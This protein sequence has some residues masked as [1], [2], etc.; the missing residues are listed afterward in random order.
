MR[1]ACDR[2]GPN[3]GCVDPRPRRRRAYL[4]GQL[5]ATLPL[6][7]VAATL[8]TTGIHAALRSQRRSAEIAAGYATINN[9]LD[10]LRQ[11]TRAATAARA[12]PTEEGV[13]AF[14]LQ[15]LDGQISYSL[16]GGRVTRAAGGPDARGKVTRQWRIKEADLSA[17]CD[18]PL[19]ASGDQ[20]S[21]MLEPR[22]P[23]SLLMVHIR[24]RGESKHQVDPTRRFDATFRIGRGYQR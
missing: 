11:D 9:L 13:Y 20:H 18:T 16:A 12:M 5:V 24:W 1:R 15:T 21:S 3:R 23:V 17:E 14:T 2:P 6:L 10:T 22:S 19:T 8:L 4:L 7:L